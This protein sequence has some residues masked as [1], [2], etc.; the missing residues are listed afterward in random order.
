MNRSNETDILIKSIIGKTLNEAKELASFNG[1]STRVTREDSI[2]YVV[3]MDLRFD[4][5]NLQ[6]DNG[7]VTK[8]NIG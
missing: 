2:N 1:Y 3:T 7:V 5:I 4:R 6:L 8:C